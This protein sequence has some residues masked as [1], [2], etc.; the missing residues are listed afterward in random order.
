M[1]PLSTEKE[2]FL[3]FCLLVISN[4]NSV[5]ICLLEF[6]LKQQQLTFEQFLQKHQHDIYHLSNVRP[7]CCKCITDR[8][9]KRSTP[10][11]SILSKAQIDVL[12]IESLFQ[13]NCG[14]YCCNRLQPKQFIKPSILDLTI[15]KCLLTYF[16]SDIFWYCCLQLRQKDLQE[17]LNE[18][19]HIIYHLNIGSRTCCHCKTTTSF[20][21]YDTSDIIK[22]EE[23]LFLYKV[24]NTSNP[25][26]KCCSNHSIRIC[27]LSANVLSPFSIENHVAFYIQQHCCETRKAL[28]VI[29]EIRNTCYAHA[30]EALLSQNEFE[31]K[32]KKLVGAIL[33]LADVCGIKEETMADIET[34]MNTPLDGMGTKGK[35]DEV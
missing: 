21:I 19:K 3:R 24:T 33:T 22:K 15:A 23:L 26:S 34:S 32:K 11:R 2:N 16:C 30:K 4:A 29:T 5:V 14:R 25:Q 27:E 12:Y 10:T 31:T 7:K 8:N 28:E 1:K 13:N 17:F 6:S 35:I 9:K 18:K 20:S